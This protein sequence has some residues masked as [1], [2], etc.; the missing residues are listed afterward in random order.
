MDVVFSSFLHDS[1]EVIQI[2]FVIESRSGVFDGFP[3]D[4]ETQEGQ[5]PFVQT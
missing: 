4:Q 3:G 5:P 2:G 1:I